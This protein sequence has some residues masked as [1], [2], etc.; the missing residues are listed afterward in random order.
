[1]RLPVTDGTQEHIDQNALNNMVDLYL[2]RGFTYFDTS[3]VYHNGASETAIRE[4]LVKRHDRNSKLALILHFL[5]IP[6]AGRSAAS[7]KKGQ[8]QA[9]IS[10]DRIG[11]HHLI[12]S[13]H[14]D[15]H[16]NDQPDIDNPENNIC[17][18]T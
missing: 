6:K 15:H 16:G 4:A 13:C 18:I 8:Q 5:L 9:D 1:M 11:I 12:N 17:Q 3:Y 7:Q 14:G 10:P 2:E